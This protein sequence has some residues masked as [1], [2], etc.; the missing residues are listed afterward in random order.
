MV[1]TEHPSA[2]Q[3][4]APCGDLIDMMHAYDKGCVPELIVQTRV[5]QPLVRALAYLH[6][7]SIIHRDIKPENVV[8]GEDGFARLCDF[9]LAINT[10]RET[11][12]SR[13][14]TL[15]FMAP[16]LIRLSTTRSTRELDALRRRFGWPS[17]VVRGRACSSLVLKRGVSHR[18]EHIYSNKVDI[19]AMGCLTYEMLVGF[20]PFCGRASG[21]AKHAVESSRVEA[22]I[23]HAHLEF[24]PAATAV[25]SVP[26]REFIRNALCKVA[27]RRPN[28]QVRF[29]KTGAFLGEGKPSPTP[30]RAKSV[31]LKESQ[32]LCLRRRWWTPPRA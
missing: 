15:E 25:I 2:P 32:M 24:P 7:R 3:E 20:S 31:S 1:A 5:L 19:W 27:A 29:L 16:E 9:G 28:A 18:G 17:T 10:S 8:I 26:M 22:N 12:V 6:E 14:G 23:M 30:P 13:V 11:P 4:L 21:K